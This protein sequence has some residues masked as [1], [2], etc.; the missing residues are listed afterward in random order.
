MQMVF[1]LSCNKVPEIVILHS[2]PVRIDF[3]ENALTYD[4]LMLLDRSVK[5]EWMGYQGQGENEGNY[6]PGEIIPW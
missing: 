3:Q 4:L 1:L 5:A 6:T 2:P